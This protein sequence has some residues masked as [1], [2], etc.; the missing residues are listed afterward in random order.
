MPA[1]EAFTQRQEAEIDR[2]VSIA[3]R[4]GNL[5]VSV[6]VGALGGEPR[7]EAERLHGLLADAS[8][9]VLVAVDPGT[10]RLEIVTGPY[11][12]HRLDERSCALAGL[13]MTSAFTAGDLTGGIVAGVQMLGEHARGPR[14]LHTD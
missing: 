14:V 8:G 6:Y 10:R 9:A 4:E 13:T 2:A 7:A 3:D 1:G 12:A 11:L 5:P